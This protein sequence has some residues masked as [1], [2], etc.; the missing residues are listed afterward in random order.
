MPSRSM[1]GFI[2]MPQNQN[3]GEAKIH[4]PD[5]EGW[6]DL[7]YGL[8]EFKMCTCEKKWKHLRFQILNPNKFLFSRYQGNHPQHF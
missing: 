8:S 7:G 5:K 6:T 1:C 3:D 2:V 4:L